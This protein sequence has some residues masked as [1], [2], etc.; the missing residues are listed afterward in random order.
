MIPIQND[1]SKVSEEYKMCT[2]QIKPC[3]ENIML[4]LCFWQTKK[5][6]GIRR[7]GFMVKAMAFLLQQG[8]S[9]RL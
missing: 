1:L 6:E 5:T 7:N 2:V 9:K 8:K 3:S 4:E